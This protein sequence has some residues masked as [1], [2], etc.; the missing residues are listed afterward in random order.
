MNKLILLIATLSVFF[1]CKNNAHMPDA[2]GNFE[3]DET[4]VSSEISGKI[5]WFN[6]NEGEVIEAQK[7]VALIDTIM[8]TLQLSE[9]EAQH[10]RIIANMNSIDAQSG[11]YAQQ[12][13]NLNVDFERLKNM[14]ESGAATQKQ[15]DDI[16]GALKVI[17]KQIEANTMQKAAVAKEIEV[18]NSKKQLIYEQLS[19]CRVKNPLKGTVL[20]KYAESGEITA[21]GKPL[22]KISDISNIVLR[23]YVSGAQ[24]YAIQKGSKCKILIDKGAKAYKEYSGTITWISSKA[25]FT[26]KIIQT[27]EERVNMVYA[28]KIDVPNDGSIKIGM[29]GEVMFSQHSNND[30]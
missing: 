5:L 18:L 22:Y 17:E 2:Y 16:S 29:P 3:A 20:E 25:E 23:A 11:I 14:K 26:P 8:P 15:L 24:I 12:R 7:T 10:K 6:I 1:S 13:E 27:K 19:K 21:A 4:M 9:I 28:V 30:Q